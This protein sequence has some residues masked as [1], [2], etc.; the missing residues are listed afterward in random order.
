MDIMC[1]VNTKHKKNVRMDNGLKVLYLR[2]LKA[3]YGCMDSALM[4][5]DLYSK[6]LKPQGF[7]INLYARCI[8]NFTSQDKQCTTV[9]YF[10]NNKVSHLDEEVKTNVIERISEHYGNLAVSRGKKQRFLGM[11][12]YFLAD[13]KLSLFMKDYIE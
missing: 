10:D 13:G 9:W 7:L 11:D 6:T 3:L 2:L 4:W 5:Y 1:K 12:I 8:A